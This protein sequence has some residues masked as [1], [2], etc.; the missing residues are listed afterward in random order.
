MFRPLR[1]LLLVKP[2]EYVRSD[3]LKVVH[4]SKESQG[5]VV[6]TG[7]GRRDKRGKLIPLDA[8]PGDL[9]RFGTEDGYLT[10]TQIKEGS[11][12]LLLMSEADVCFVQCNE[13]S[14]S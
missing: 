9:V 14:V 5:V 2:V 6:A 10:Y 1:D 3:V 13:E 8:K 11:E 7:P 4:S 12:T